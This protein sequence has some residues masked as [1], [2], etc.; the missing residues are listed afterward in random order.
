MKLI[1]SRRLWNDLHESGGVGLL[2]TGGRDLAG[3]DLA[4]RAGC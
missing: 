2:G 4:G 3:S 1:L